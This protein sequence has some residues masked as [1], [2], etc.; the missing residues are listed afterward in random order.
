MLLFKESSYVRDFT[1]QVPLN[2]GTVR[3]ALTATSTERKPVHIG[4][5]LNRTY[6]FHTDLP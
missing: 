6:N 5:Q 2:I 1:V 3:Q 4:H